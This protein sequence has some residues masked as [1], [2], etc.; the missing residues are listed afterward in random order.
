[1]KM[2]QEQANKWRK[3]TLRRLMTNISS[4][5]LNF[6]EKRY[7]GSDF[8]YCKVQNLGNLIRDLAISFKPYDNFKWVD[9]QIQAKELIKDVQKVERSLKP[10][11]EASKKVVETVEVPL[12]KR[13]F[14]VLTS[15]NLGFCLDFKGQILDYW[16]DD[17]RCDQIV[18]G[19][20]EFDANG[21]RAAFGGSVSFDRKNVEEVF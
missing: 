4:R 10:K 7:P 8:H 19:Q 20:P 17:R 18:L 12:V 14:R 3:R 21:R 13:R 9:L 15:G 2:T 6:E 11:K 5:I 16:H 1:M